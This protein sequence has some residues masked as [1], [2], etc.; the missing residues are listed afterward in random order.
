M[1]K[2]LLIIL[3]L[4]ATLA[5]AEEKKVTEINEYM[6]DIYFG[7]GILTT[8]E[9]ARKSQKILFDRYHISKYGGLGRAEIEKAKKEIHFDLAYN[10]SFKESWGEGVGAIFDLM[11]SYEQL[12]N[13]SYGWKAFN[14]LVKLADELAVKKNP[15]G[16]VTKK[17]I[18]DWL[19]K[20]LIN[21]TLAEFM[22]IHLS[23]G[24][25][26]KLKQI[27][28]SGIKI[29]TKAVHDED[30]KIQVES[31]KWSIKS[32]H[33]VVVVSHS[34]GNLFA[35]Q[36]YAELGK[37]DKWMLPY[38][39]QVSIASPATKTV[40]NVGHITFDN[41]AIT[42]VIGGLEGNFPNPL[43]YW[44]WIKLVDLTEYEDRENMTLPPEDFPIFDGSGCVDEKL[45]RGTEPSCKLN[46]GTPFIQT[47]YVARD[48]LSED[49]HAFSYYMKESTSRDEIFKMI[50]NRRELYRN[51]KSQW[52]P[53]NLGCICKEK[54]IAMTHKHDPEKMDI[55]LEDKKVKDFTSVSGGEG[56]IY[57]ITEQYVKASFGG[58]N[59]EEISEDNSD[60]CYV[61]KDEDLQEIGEIRGSTEPITMPKAGVVEVTITWDNP[62]IDFDLNVGWN[63]GEH[64]VK[65]TGCG[66]EHFYVGS[67]Y[68]IYPGTYP[69]NVTYKKE[70]EDE[71]G[72][73]PEKVRVM[74]KVPQEPVEIYEIDINTTS[75]LDVGHIADIFVK[76]VDNKL[77]PEIQ[78]DPVMP[79]PTIAPDGECHVGSWCNSSGGSGG[80]GSGGGGGGSS[81]GS[82][83]GSGGGHSCGDVPCEYKIIPFLEQLLFGPIAGA[84]F[85]LY[86]ISDKALLYT[87]QTTQGYTLYT[88]GNIEIPDNIISQLD[89]KALYML[90]ASGGVDI[91]HDDD[92]R[93]DSIPTANQG[94][95]HL[96]ITGKEAKEIGFKMNVLTEIAYQVT[97]DMIDVNTTQ[98]IINKL[99]EISLRLLKEKIYRDS[100][101]VVGYKDLL[102]WLPT[103]HQNMLFADY[104]GMVVPLIENLFANREIYEQAYKIV[105]HHMDTVPLLQSKRYDIDEELS[106]GSVVGNIIVT[107][108]GDS[109]IESFSLVGEGSENFII[110]K[111]GTI[112]VAKDAHLD[113]E[114]QTYYRFYVTATNKDGISK[115]VEILIQLHNIHDSPEFVNA[116]YNNVYENT[117]VGD[118]VLEVSFNQGT[119]ALQS[120]E[121]FGNSNE[122]FMA[123]VHDNNVSIKVANPLL[124]FVV[125]RAYKF[126]LQVANTTQ[127]SKKI[128]FTMV[129]RDRR[130]IPRLG[131]A[132]HLRVDEN[133]TAGTT[134]GK[135]NI[136][137]D[138]Y[139]PIEYFKV[140]ARDDAQNILT[141]W[142]NGYFS[143]DKN[144]T[145]R[146]DSNASLDYETR[147]DYS[148]YIVAVNAIGESKKGFIRV[149]LNDIPDTLPTC[150]SDILELGPISKGIKVESSLGYGGCYT[151]DS[152]F[153]SAK[154]EP[155]SPFEAAIYTDE[156]GAKYI[157]IQVVSALKNIDVSEYNLSLSVTN[158]TGE[159]NK[160]P[161]HIV[162][163]QNS[164]VFN[165]MQGD[166][167]T[168]VGQIDINVTDILNI[169]DDNGYFDIDTNGTIRRNNGAEYT[170][171]P[172]YAYTITVT[173]T[174]HSREEIA[175]VVNVQSRVLSQFSIPGDATKIILNK[176]KT[177]AYV[178]NNDPNSYNN[179]RGL[180]IV[181]IENPYNPQLISSLVTDGKSKDIVLSDDEKYIYLLDA[182][183]GLK[184]IDINDE[185]NP[186]VAT[187]LAFSGVNYQFG[188]IDLSDD[189]NTLYM[190]H[191]TYGIEVIDVSDP[192]APITVQNIGF[193][194]TIE[195]GGD[196][197]NNKNVPAGGYKDIV[198]KGTRLYSIDW[199]YGL[200]VIEIS[201][202]E[203]PV[204]IYA[205]SLRDGKYNYSATD[206]YLHKKEKLISVIS[207]SDVPMTL[208]SIVNNSINK[209]KQGYT[210]D[211]FE[212]L[213]NDIAFLAKGSFT[214]YDA[215][216]P[217]NMEK[218]LTINFGYVSGGALKSM[219]L[220]KEKNIAYVTNENSGIIAIN[221]DG[222]E[223]P[224][225]HEPV[226][227]GTDITI[228]EENLSS[229]TLDDVLGNV[230]ILK[231]GDTPIVKMWTNFPKNEFGEVDCGYTYYAQLI[232]KNCENDYSYFD[233]DTMGNIMAN[234]NDTLKYES[235]GNMMPFTVYAENENNYIGKQ[236]KVTINIKENPEMSIKFQKPVIKI[237]SN[238]SIGDV[239]GNVVSEP[240]KRELF[241]FN[242]YSV[243]KS[244]W[245]CKS[246]SNVMDGVSWGDIHLVDYINDFCKQSLYFSIEN[247][248]DIV[249]DT[250]PDE[251]NYTVNIFAV[252]RFGLKS[253]DKLQIEML[254]L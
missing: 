111:N 19:V 93:A 142:P 236:A 82:G 78:P 2:V 86:E 99:H 128:P 24:D 32:G 232:D 69:I 213:D 46:D 120:A 30:L 75:E 89:D 10:Y 216:N 4:V 123:E 131:Y 15:I 252:D 77:V 239:V 68:D 176:A 115:P 244:G 206:I 209:I 177:R 139:S 3:L 52:K 202:L 158:A 167:N 248:G 156:Y 151:R 92:M 246:V 210:Y 205:E 49:F 225:H 237:G 140:V 200:Q 215:Y 143:I 62:S 164:Y 121:L 172:Q 83:G 178:T 114:T 201:D 107:D 166:L 189:G 34:Q 100:E 108:I 229:I 27:G 44:K 137:S 106:A 22:A 196:N 74:I 218:L 234:S 13:T 138:G 41:D 221:F 43:R 162:I 79:T 168:I 224:L 197:H 238:V 181:N 152:S 145:I 5:T 1:K 29:A 134:V 217:T 73:I 112:V 67:Q 45:P 144:G 40:K 16:T 66:M 60:L 204:S 159:S 72:L 242:L 207:T 14:M 59:I 65:D 31:Y 141:E 58:A 160:R 254:K 125:H 9:E 135:V 194:G 132:W 47:Q 174:D 169:Y 180:V 90:E 191:G 118:T 42:V 245:Y 6:T 88:A 36:A 113:Y 171:T 223:Q 96:L 55:L 187:A 231:T 214:I 182:G 157:G 61:L 57:A 249:I 101:G 190:A 76:Y 230:F 192:V 70:L 222:I 35:L 136:I 126:E 253:L 165:M 228:A 226:L 208:Y 21:D 163:D 110:E 50:D 122:Y 17:L 33:G 153:V 80:G 179:G 8:K 150:Q 240:S 173:H 203:N 155:S 95:M 71:S 193:L 175:V 105:Y 188:G 219:A 37:T 250:I 186:Y 109:S 38:F 183:K 149:N 51:E 28:L 241:L 117:A 243:E 220:D 251:G 103:I 170:Y 119:S 81:G 53:K 7:N 97:K 94:T 98:E 39:H 91:D 198:A 130:D 195:N 124:E 184:V 211:N 146:V 84:D 129:L 116:H 199:N 104:Q 87:G 235:V 233:V 127:R 154:L 185:N 20:F 48:S 212:I 18:K 102:Y 85:N 23:A 12:D 147:R 26:A 133:A 227:T 25:L 56:K 64:D 148:A 11:E 63:T 54:Y 247:N 161:I